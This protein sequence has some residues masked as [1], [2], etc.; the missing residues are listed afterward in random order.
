MV[1]RYR[2]APPKNGETELMSR[3]LA[4]QFQ[5]EQLHRAA[6]NGDLSEV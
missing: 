2:T 4:A 1:T 6:E 5:S 3:R